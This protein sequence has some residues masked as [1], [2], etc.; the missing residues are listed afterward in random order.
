[1]QEKRL[2]DYIEAMSKDDYDEWF[3][4]IENEEKE[5]RNFLKKS[6]KLLRKFFHRLQML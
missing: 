2:K 5:L 1:M 6:M 4:D 3:A